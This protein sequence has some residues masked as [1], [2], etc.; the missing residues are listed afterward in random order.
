MHGGDVLAAIAHG[1]QFTYVGRAYLYGL[2]AGGQEGVERT[3][4]ILKGQMSR[5][6]KLIGVSS[7]EE[8]EPRHVKILQ[9]HHGL[10]KLV[11]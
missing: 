8:L 6:M 5:S 10:G 1:A 9:T 3:L 4:E 2:M 11:K 7:L